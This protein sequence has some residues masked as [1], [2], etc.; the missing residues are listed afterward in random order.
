MSL[1]LVPVEY[2]LVLQL[3]RVL[4]NLLATFK[5]VTLLNMFE[6]EQFLMSVAHVVH[7]EVHRRTVACRGK[8]HVPH[9]DRDIDLFSPRKW[10]L[11]SPILLSPVG[12]VGSV[13]LV[14]SIG[15]AGFTG[16]VLGF[17]LLI[18]C[19]DTVLSPELLPCTLG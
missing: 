15:L 13:V 3:V 19:C 14:V 10:F 12:L 5:P 17:L 6:C 7:T 2:V 8:H 16:L 9:D 1:L 4:P 18:V 11:P